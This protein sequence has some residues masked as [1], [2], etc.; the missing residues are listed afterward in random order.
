MTTNPSFRRGMRVCI[1]AGR[2][3]GELG[4]VQGSEWDGEVYERYVLLDAEEDEEGELELF[5]V[6]K[7]RRLDRGEYFLEQVQTLKKPSDARML[8]LLL[9]LPDLTRPPGF[10]RKMPSA[11]I[12]TG[13]LLHIKDMPDSLA[14]LL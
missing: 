14:G 1:Q 4:T 13:E 9:N 6:K 3:R 5:N 2:H 12:Q 7:L 11:P 10:R 8:T